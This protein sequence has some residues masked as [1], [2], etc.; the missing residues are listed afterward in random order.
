M[1]NVNQLSLQHG[2]DVIKALDVTL[3]RIVLHGNSVPTTRIEWVN[4]QKQLC[5]CKRFLLYLVEIKTG[6]LEYDKR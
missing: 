2:N 1:N 6:K 5:R 3:N 4:R